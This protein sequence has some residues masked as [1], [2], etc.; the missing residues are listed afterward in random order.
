[1]VLCG[2]EYCLIGAL[3]CSSYK[4]ITVFTIHFSKFTLNGINC[5]LAGN[6]AAAMAAQAIATENKCWSSLEVRK[7][8]LHCVTYQSTVCDRAA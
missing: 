8:N 7:T 4:S 5:H 6:T 1:M 3:D 2:A